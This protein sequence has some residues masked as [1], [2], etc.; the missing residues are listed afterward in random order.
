VRIP[1]CVRLRRDGAD[2]VAGIAPDVSLP[3]YA[4]E[5]SAQHAD[6]IIELAAARI[7]P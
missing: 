5:S 1:N 3:S 2:E 6:R 7:K 4:G